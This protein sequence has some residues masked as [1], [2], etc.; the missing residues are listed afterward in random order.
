MPP[1]C[2]TCVITLHQC[3][4]SAANTLML[5]SISGLLKQLLHLNYIEHTSATNA[6]FLLGTTCEKW[7]IWRIAKPDSPENV[8][9]SLVKG[10]YGK[11]KV[12]KPSSPKF[13]QQLMAGT[14]GCGVEQ[15]MLFNNHQL[16]FLSKAVLQKYSLVPLP[17]APQFEK[18]NYNICHNKADYAVICS[19]TPLQPINF[20][21]LD[22][23]LFNING[24]LFP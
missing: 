6:S 23:R 16:D 10:A 1:L 20:P 12:T 22:L 5:A 9:G 7:Q 2:K 15:T 14:M 18:Y 13:K 19:Y 24:C 3:T 21:L 4:N 17:S 11:A 8:Q